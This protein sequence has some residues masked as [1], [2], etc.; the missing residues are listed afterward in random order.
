[1]SV[2]Q[3]YWLTFAPGLILAGFLGGAPVFFAFFAPTY[4][5]YFAHRKEWTLGQ[6]AV[7]ATVLAIALFW[8]FTSNV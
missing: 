3:R 4:L 6:F 1:M 7:R 5:C 8:F 2:T